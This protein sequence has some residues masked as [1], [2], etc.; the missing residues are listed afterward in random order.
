MGSSVG[1][2]VGSSVG[3]SVGLSVGS[4]DGASEGVVRGAEVARPRGFQGG[5]ASQLSESERSSSSRA[6]VAA[7]THGSGGASPAKCDSMAYMTSLVR[8]QPPGAVC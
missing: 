7:A 5:P 3:S 1:L 8:G 2:S 4:S 6:S